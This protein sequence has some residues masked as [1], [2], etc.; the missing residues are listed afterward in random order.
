MRQ[1]CSLGG[2]G[3]I[4]DRLTNPAERD[5]RMNKL[6]VAA[7]AAVVGTAIYLPAAFARDIGSGAAPLRVAEAGAAAVL[8]QA[9]HYEWQYHY[10]GHHS[11]FA[12]HWVLVQ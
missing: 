9:P 11:R 2:A 5:Q 6:Y 7:A 10:I 3:P 8:Q 4:G 1:E 12:G